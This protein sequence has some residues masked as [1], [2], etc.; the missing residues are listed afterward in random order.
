MPHQLHR[1]TALKS[2]AVVPAGYWLGTS[3]QTVRAAAAS[4]KLN[5]ACIGVGGRGGANLGGVS[6]QNIVAMCDCDDKMA[7][8]AYKKHP[9]AKK[10]H[11]FRQMFDKMEKQI[12]AVVVSTPDHTHF[13]PSMMAL[14]RGMHL[15]CEK[16]L[17][18]N[19]AQVRAITEKAREKKLATQLGS[20]RHAMSNMSRVVEAIQ[21][22][23]IGNVSEVHSWVGGSRGMPK[24]PTGEQ[25]PVPKTLD[26]DLWQGPVAE[27]KYSPAYVPYK[28]RFWW[29]YGTGETGNWGCHILDI[30]F[31]ALNLSF[32]TKVA[33]SGP[34]VDPLRTPNSMQTRFE[35]PA[36]GKR[37]PV[38]LHWSHGSP[39]ALHEKHKGLKI[40]KG[41]N[42]VFIGSKGV[43]S[44]DFSK[45]SV[46]LNDKT[47]KFER[48]K[49]TIAKSPGFYNEWF[50][51][52]RGGAPA[53]C[54]FDYSGP[55]AE[56][57]LLGNVAYRAQGEFEWDHKT[58]TAKGSARAAELISE[59][60]RKGWEI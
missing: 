40:P 8:K 25:P 57:V 14:S 46:V 27:K 6:S 50:R 58:L 55:L 28:W 24:A 48:P 22:G 13:H 59:P 42:T 10:F 49:A 36:D 56:T 11:D 9:K 4:D 3:S 41:T 16:P 7:A 34:A 1:R 45:H 35:F 18:H 19:V 29:D 53:T 30:P 60:Y 51:A 21:S 52:C 5:I 15:Y 23:A 20:Q 26:W 47:A 2:L 17:A 54:N 43:L 39:V 37:P 38:V 33:G 32:P 12:D 44:T 31:W